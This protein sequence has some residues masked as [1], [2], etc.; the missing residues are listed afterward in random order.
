[1][2][3][4]IPVFIQKLYWSLIWKFR[5]RQREIYLTFD[6]GPHPEVTPRVLEILD[7]YH[8]KATFFCIGRNVERFPEVFREIINRG[9][10]VGNHTYSHLKGWRTKN[11]DYYS[12]IEI[13]G[14]LI[15]SKLFRPP[16]GRIKRTQFKKLKKHYKIIMWNVLSYDYSDVVSY[17]KSRRIVL[18][19][20]KPG[21][22]LVFHDSKK[23]EPKVL[24]LLPDVL[25]ELRDRNYTFAKIEF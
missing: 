15:P 7:Q 21:S 6:D 4:S 25:Q 2:V 10:A 11:E 8:A 12:D 24:K 23:A 17:K 19:H 13:A 20:T 18:N 1:M 3:G 16:Y 14:K 5:P 9:H 22:I